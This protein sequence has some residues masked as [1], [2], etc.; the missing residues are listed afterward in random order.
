M[1]KHLKGDAKQRC[2]HWCERRSAGNRYVNARWQCSR[3]TWH[4]SGYCAYHRLGYLSRWSA[5]DEAKWTEHST[6]RTKP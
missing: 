3:E 1:T 5:E 4:P 6:E 2:A